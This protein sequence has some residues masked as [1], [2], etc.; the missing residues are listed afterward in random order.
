MNA[1]DIM[2]DQK[3]A[4]EVIDSEV[5]TSIENIEC[6]ENKEDRRSTAIESKK[7][8][9]KEDTAMPDHVEIK[10]SREQ[11]YNEIWEISVMGVAQKYNLPYA[12]LLKICKEADIPIPPSGYWT[13]ISFGKPVA[14][15]SLPVFDTNII[16]L[17]NAKAPRASKMKA[18]EKDQ[19]FIEK[20]VTV[21]PISSLAAVASKEHKLESSLITSDSEVELPDTDQVAAEAKEETESV[22]TYTQWGHTYNIYEREILYK[23]VWEKPVIE[24]AK[25]YGVSDVTIHKICKSLDIPTPPHGYWAKVYAGKA[26][27][28]IPLSKSDK[29]AQKSGIRTDLETN[30][31]TETGTLDFLEE[32][33]RAMIFAIANQI[34]LPDDGAKMHPKI[35]AHRRLVAEW[36]KSNKRENGTYRGS[37]YSR[38]S[39][40]FLADSVSEETLPRV[41]HI[42]DALIHAMGPLGCSLAD[43]LQF[44]VLGETVSLMITE[45]MDEVP[46]VN[47]KEENMQLLKYEADRKRYSY[48]SKPNI[49]KYDHN[50][51]GRISITVY[52]LKNYRDC[53]SYVVEDRLGDIL[54]LMYETSN[55]L[56]K[57]REA[58]EEAE[59]K[60]KEEERLREERRNCYNEE[61]DRTIALTNLAEDYDAACKIRHYISAVESSKELDEKTLSWIEWAKAKADW[62]DPTIA[63]ED[64]IFGKRDH[65]ENDDQKELEHARYSRW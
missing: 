64:E 56:R 29:P 17:S 28:R 61:V 15:T 47:T 11:L 4:D 9:G 24:V 58:R 10:M 20:R 2:L 3:I 65:E 55:I 45:S 14:K 23:E 18:I 7:V 44:V 13:K 12:Q 8:T 26:V 1:D 40:P 25:K 59:R 21:D 57:E 46:H 30:Q 42:L 16:T 35:I 49:R 34:Q 37:R 41:F 38:E 62:F 52:N 51:N 31:K 43:D 27:T 48:A 5:V 63:R 32:E 6:L 36:N 54:I 53:K 60:R 33:E 22:R 19:V 39:S 50:H